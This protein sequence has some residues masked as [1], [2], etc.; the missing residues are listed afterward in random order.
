M[1]YA[2]PAAS[3][4]WAAICA[5]PPPSGFDP[6]PS[7]LMYQVRRALSS[8]LEQ[9]ARPTVNVTALSTIATLERRL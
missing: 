2:P 1:E 5:W 7:G 9:A 3:V 4:H 8:V 6:P